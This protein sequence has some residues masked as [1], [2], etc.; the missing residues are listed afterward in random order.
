MSKV[1]CL[2]CNIEVVFAIIVNGIFLG[3]NVFL[4]SGDEVSTLAESSGGGGGVPARAR[5]VAGAP[6][7]SHLLVRQRHRGQPAPR[8]ALLP[9]M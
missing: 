7:L 5:S 8:H 4:N 6:A 3:E 9:P 2:L 1:T